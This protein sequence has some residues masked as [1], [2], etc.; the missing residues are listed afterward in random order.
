MNDHY[1]TLGVRRNASSAEIKKAY[2]LLVRNYHPDKLPPGTPE[3]V[4]RDAAEKFLVIKNAFDV[5]SGSERFSYDRGLE[6]KVQSPRPSS[7]PTPPPAPPPQPSTRSV[8]VYCRQCGSEL[9]DSV[10]PRCIKQQ[11]SV[12]GRVGRG[13]RSCE[14]YLRKHPSVILLWIL[15]AA[16]GLGAAILVPQFGGSVNGSPWDAA[17]CSE[18]LALLA[19]VAIVAF[20]KKG[21]TGI[22]RG[23]KQLCTARPFTG[24]LAVQ[25][26]I[27]ATISLLVGATQSS[28]KPN[29][30]QQQS[31]TEFLRARMSGQFTGTVLNRTV[32]QSAQAELALQ[33]SNDLLTGC[34]AVL[35]PLFGSGDVTGSVHDGRFEFVAHSPNFDIKFNGQK[36]GEDLRGTY[37][38]TR[39]GTGLQNGAFEFSRSRTALADGLKSSDCPT[40]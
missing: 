11:S 8:D 36:N 7:S 17:V 1:A 14:N 22:W 6:T 2:L 35:R 23:I 31:F 32:N 4:K 38:V 34:F 5:L 12:F 28:P 9:N 15:F 33:Q 13:W 25:L 37:V 29:I 40:D 16:V 21:V 10:C 39:G 19:F 18:F 26:T 27:L 24:T 30:P 3:L 20:F